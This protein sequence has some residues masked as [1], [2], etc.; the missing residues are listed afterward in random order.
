MAMCSALNFVGTALILPM[1]VW[2]SNAQMS[3]VGID[4]NGLSMIQMYPLSQD[5]PLTKSSSAAEGSPVVQLPLLQ[6]GQEREGVHQKTILD[7]RNGTARYQQLPANIL[8]AFTDIAEQQRA[9]LVLGSQPGARPKIG[10]V[11]NP[12][13][14]D[15]A[16]VFEAVSISL[17]IAAPIL[18]HNPIS[19]PAD[20][21]KVPKNIA[22][23]QELVRLGKKCVVYGLGIADNSEFETKMADLGCQT[24]AFDCSISPTSAAVN[25]KAFTFHNWCIGKKGNTSF[26][27]NAYVG[28]QNAQAMQFKT[29]AETMK[30]LGHDHISLLKFDIEGFEWGLFANEIL[31]SPNGQGLP[32]QLAFELHTEGANPE[33]VPKDN[34]KGK[35]YVAVNH[36]F[37]E[38]YDKGYRV[39]SKEVNSGDHACAEFVLVN[40]N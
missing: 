33:Y 37:L 32:E 34:T 4:S 19:N 27:G 8:Q 6:I 14:K 26:E 13:G 1:L 24:H 29:L 21:E 25:K 40:V 38:L 18:D 15:K 35:D 7:P 5:T 16:S 3:A 39:V 10:P 11:Q 30:L 23:T 17:P 36:L 12:K 9:L 31:A 20:F 22:A 2:N 28:K